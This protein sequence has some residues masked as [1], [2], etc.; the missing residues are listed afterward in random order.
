[1]PAAHWN[2]SARSLIA[3]GRFPKKQEH[4]MQFNHV[5]IWFAYQGFQHIAGSLEVPSGLDRHLTGRTKLKCPEFRPSA[6]VY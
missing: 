3:M 4:A 5:A 2:R 6:V 1:M